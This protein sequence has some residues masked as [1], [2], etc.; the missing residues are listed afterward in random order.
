MANLPTGRKS[1]VWHNIISDP[2]VG[3]PFRQVYSDKFNDETSDMLGDLSANEIED[4][5]H[6]QSVGRIGCHDEDLVYVV[7]I[8]YAYDDN[9][10][11]CHTYEGK[12]IDIMRMNPKVCFQ[13]DEMRDMANWRSV[14]AWGQ[15]EELSS[16]EEKAEALLILL[17]RQ[18]PSPSSITTHLGKSWPFT[19]PN[20]EDLV[21]IPGITFRISLTEKTGRFES[22]SESP[23]LA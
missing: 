9:C 16:Q 10:V 6:K 20:K 14:I 5:L 23:M 17:H 4:L 1:L 7:P 22:T 3:H 18:L 12:K 13:V 8:S 11:Y 15:F 19:P 21:N 2:D